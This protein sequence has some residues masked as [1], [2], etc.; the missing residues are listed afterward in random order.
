MKSRAGKAIEVSDV[1][2]MQMRE[3]DV[4]DRAGIDVEQSQRFDGT[5]QESAFPP[6]RHLRVE[7]GVDDKPASP[8][9]G[10]PHEIVHRHRAIMRL[11]A[12]EG[13]GPPRL[14]GGVADGEELVFR[15]GH[16]VSAQK[17]SPGVPIRC[18]GP[19]N[20]SHPTMAHCPNA[21]R[22]SGHAMSTSW[23]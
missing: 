17:I 12:D 8:A 9:P 11:A 15:P 7:A 18:A 2:V 10:E 21:E 4:L 19:V 6:R 22:T 5:A 1:V 23:R 14:A 13:I 16:D 20:L 3:N